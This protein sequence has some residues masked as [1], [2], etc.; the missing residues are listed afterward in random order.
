MKNSIIRIVHETQWRY[1]LQNEV[2]KVHPHIEQ[3]IGAVSKVFPSLS[4]FH[5]TTQTFHI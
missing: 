4:Y 1:V 3:T 2:Q 5:L